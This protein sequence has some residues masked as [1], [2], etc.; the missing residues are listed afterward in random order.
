M[1]ISVTCPKCQTA[2]RLADE[3]AGKKLKCQIC[4]GAITLPP[5]ATA[6]RPKSDGNSTQVK[7]EPASA[8]ADKKPKPAKNN[9]ARKDADSDENPAVTPP[10]NAKTGASRGLMITLIL[11]LG[12]G[13]LGCLGCGGVVAWRYYDP[14]N[15][16]KP[17]LKFV[18][19]NDTTQKN[20]GDQRAKDKKQIDAGNTDGAAKDGPH[21]DGKKDGPPDDGSKDSN[22]PPLDSKKDNPIKDNKAPTPPGEGKPPAYIDVGGYS[23]RTFSFKKDAHPVGDLVWARDRTSFYVLTEAGLLQ[24]F[25]ADTGATIR[26]KDYAQKCGNLALSGQGLLLS[27]LDAQ[28]VWIVDPEN[29]DAVQK[30]IPVPSIARVTAGSDATY[31]VAAGGAKT[32]LHV[33]D[34]ER[35]AVAKSFP[36]LGARHVRASPNGRYVFAQGAAE[37]LLRFRLEKDQLIQEDSSPRIALNGQSVCVSPDSQH[38]CFAA[39]DGNGQGHPNHPPASPRATFI[40]PVTNLKRPLCV[41]NSGP[42]PQ[43]VGFDPKG[44]FVV[45]QNN[46]KPIMIF[47]YTGNKR[48]EF[49]VK[50]IKG[51]DVR[52]FSVSPLG[53]EML[54]RTDD[55]VVHVKM[56]KKQ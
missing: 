10:Q 5:A 21:V 7:S 42:N 13:L 32:G 23:H 24:Q 31:A 51:S 25:S 4:Q 18:A 40:Y 1:P 41:L 26:E 33:I 43:A 2:Y 55:R 46:V 9:V 22:P 29:L 6:A 50:N 3:M 38:V 28:E 44:G 36:D 20:K 19:V 45:A 52:E 11:F 12:V 56:T 17:D 53:F 15:V 8:A 48:A 30:K 39:A 34:L 54:I 16:A 27:M 14:A 47:N 49:E 37:Q 35:G